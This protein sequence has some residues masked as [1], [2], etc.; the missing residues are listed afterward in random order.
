MLFG[1]ALTVAVT[2]RFVEI[3]PLTIVELVVIELV[4]VIEA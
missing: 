1:I 3:N 2:A 4:D